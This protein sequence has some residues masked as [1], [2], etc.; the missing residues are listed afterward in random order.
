LPK[1]K[2]L[3]KEFIFIIGSPRS[4]T[5]WLQLMLGAHPSVC[6]TTELRLY[7]KYLAPW[8]EAWKTEA[9]MAEG[10][11]SYIGLPVLWKEGEFHDFLRDFLDLAYSKVLATKPD[12]THILDKHPGYTQFVEGINYFVPQARFIHVIRDGRDVAVSL[13]EASRKLGWFGR[14]P[15]YEYANLW[16]N[17]VLD[18]R[19]AAAFSGRYKEVRYEDLS[20]SPITGLKSIFEFCGVEAGD[21]LVSEIVESHKFENLKKSRSTPAEGV[22]VPEGHF[23]EGKVGNWGRHFSAAN[24]Y[25][26]DKAAGNLLRELG[27]AKERWWA[28]HAHERI[29]APVAGLVARTYRK[30]R[31]VEQACKVLLGSRIAVR[32][33]N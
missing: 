24:R 5:T 14:Q 6:A 27:Y 33:T 21:K 8:I 31:R 13:F 16:K 2:A 19:K 10:E 1:R 23:R 4:G 18:A 11:K 9:R 30:S 12:A 3:D 7:N 25:L 17:H 32:P 29:W 28:E 20:S 22:K 26:F 15:L